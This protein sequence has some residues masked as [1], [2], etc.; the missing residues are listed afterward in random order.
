MKAILV[1]ETGGPET[2]RLREL[3]DPEPQPGQ[4]LVRLAAAG[5]NFID[6]Y[7]RAG[8]Y[9][10]ELPFT[11]GREGAG[12]VVS[13]GSGVTRWAPGDRVAFALQPGAYAQMV[14]V[15]E[16][17]L[18]DVPSAV[19]LEVAAAAMLQGLTAHYLSYS[20]FPLRAGHSALV[21]ASAGGVGRLLVQMAKLRGAMVIAASSTDERAALALP[22][23]ADHV[24]AYREE[25]L[26]DEARRHT[27]GRGVDVVYDSVGRDTFHHSLAALRPRGMLVLYGAAS[28]AVEPFDP[29]TLRLG[30]SLFLTRPSL[31]H[32]VASRTELEDRAGDL[33][34]WI[35]SGELDVRIHRRFPL[36]EAADAHRF[37]EAGHTRGKLI[38]EVQ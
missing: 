15:D 37:M 5:V 25:D 16:Q 18:V 26:A 36:E 9:P 3:P 1:K 11:P 29:Q 4:V 23:G 10:L 2:M 27:A 31:G 20:A 14:C 7:H 19:T 32:Y 22:L 33:F 13:V 30:G 6:I 35:G 34:D 21:L 24:V 38:L 28:G 8:L 17:R 12:A